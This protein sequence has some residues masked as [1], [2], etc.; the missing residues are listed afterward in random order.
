MS[1][2]HH[3]VENG[4][5]KSGKFPVPKENQATFKGIRALTT[6]REMGLSYEYMGQRGF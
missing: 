4:G 6:L 1:E 2:I 5:F 3:I